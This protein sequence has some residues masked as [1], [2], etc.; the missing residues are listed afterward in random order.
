MILGVT[1]R[2]PQKQAAS[3]CCSGEPAFSLANVRTMLSLSL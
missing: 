1:G 3:V 2:K